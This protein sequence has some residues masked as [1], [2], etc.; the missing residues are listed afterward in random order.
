MEKFR[1]GDEIL[2]KKTVYTPLSD[3][4]LFLENS[5]YKI[6]KISKP[7]ELEIELNISDYHRTEYT[8]NSISAIYVNFIYEDMC[9]FF[10]SVAETRK[11]KLKKLK[12]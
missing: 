8:I 5:I 9:D 10:Y 3:N 11:H 1:E 2:C 7:S 12:K 4:L 6:Y